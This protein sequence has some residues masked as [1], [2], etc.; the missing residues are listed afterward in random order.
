[1]R[2]KFDLVER[3]LKIASMARGG[4][5]LEDDYPTHYLPHVGRQVMADGG[6]P[7]SADDAIATAQSIP[8]APM[9]NLMPKPM[10]PSVPSAEGRVLSSLFEGEK[11]PEGAPW[12]GR[13][14]T[15]KARLPSIAS[16]T[17]AFNK[18]I[19][20]H[21][22]LPYMDRVRNTKDAVA[23]LAPYVGMRKDKTLVPLLGTNAKLMKAQTGTE[24]TEPLEIDGLGVETAGLSLSPAF[25]MGQVNTCPRHFSC[26]DTCLGKKS[27]YFFRASGGNDL[28]A[29][30]G[31]R[32]NSLNKTIAMMQEPEAFATRLSDEITSA[33]TNAHFNGNRYGLRLNNLSDLP[34][35]IWE[36]I[37]KSH[38]D[39][40]FYDYTKM[41]Y[42]PI[43]PNHHITYSSTG[44][45]QE[46]IDNPHQNWRQVRGRLD[47][48]SNVAMA[49]TVKKGHPL[50]EFVH[51]EESG[52]KYRVVDG[53]V[54]DFRP[55]DKVKEGEDGVIIG[56]HNKDDASSSE[57]AHID[58][59]GFLVKY[60]PQYKTIGKSKSKFELDENGNKIPTNKIVTIMTQPKKGPRVELTRNKGK[61]NVE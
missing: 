51:D 43:A 26:K 45:S 22:A 18:A 37:I 35:K 2:H 4:H 16:L 46:G 34:P 20:H 60:D 5:V 59:K 30:K 12:S 61:A 33:K 47:T 25:Q 14:E 41:D 10:A 49:F 38:P 11:A 55:I 53:D 32:L 7:D 36:P 6:M 52:K 27:G 54:H 23:K 15:E 3:A 40:D 29:F 13:A 31:P 50:P 1:M 24:E 17:E 9:P 19:S 8:D 44:V 39:V 57:T 58:S 56:L 21:T 28:S 48:G 42:D